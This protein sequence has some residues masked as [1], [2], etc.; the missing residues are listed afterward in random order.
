MGFPNFICI[1]AQKAGTTWIDAQL[2]QHPSVWMPPMKEVHFFDYQY[3]EDFRRWITWHLNTTLKRELLKSV[4]AG[5]K[6]AMDWKR[7][8]YLSELATSPKRFSVEWYKQIFAYAPKG[9]ICGEITPEYS[10]IGEAGISHMRELIPDVKIIYVIRDPVARA[11]SQLKMN[12]VR[13]GSLISGKVPEDSAFLEN[14]DHPSIM[15]R[16]NYSAFVPQW[17]KYFT[18]GTEILYIP[19]KEISSNPE[20]LMRRIENFIGLP[21]HDEYDGLRKIV[22]KGSGIKRPNLVDSKLRQMMADEYEFLNTRFGAEFSS[23]I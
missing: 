3:R 14:L 21:K 18:E 4:E 16:G 8:K 7:I 5:K 13:N 22:H 19:F 11:W 1:G 12:M 9:A 2:R 10:T 17:D 20:G 15:D 23:A 6:K